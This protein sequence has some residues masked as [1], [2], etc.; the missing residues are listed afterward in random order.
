MDANIDDEFKDAV[1]EEEFTD[2]VD[3][4]AEF[5]DAEGFVV[6]LP[7]VWNFDNSFAFESE[8]LKQ[9][10]QGADP[11]NTALTKEMLTY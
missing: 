10:F 5:T 3:H 8:D 2:A 1:D 6:R 7:K 4:E 9:I 11:G